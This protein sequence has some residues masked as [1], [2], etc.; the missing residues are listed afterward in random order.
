MSHRPNRSYSGCSRS[1]GGIPT[2][3]ASCTGGTWIVTLTAALL[4]ITAASPCPDFAGRPGQLAPPSGRRRSV[5]PNALA[6]AIAKS[7]GEVAAMTR[8]KLL[9]ILLRIFGIGGLFALGAVFMPMSW[10]VAIHSWL[11]LGDMPTAPIVEY[12]ARTVSVFYVVV[13][14]V[15]LA[16]TSDLDRY[17][18]LVRLLGV[19]LALTGIVFTGTDLAAGM[20]W[21]WTAAEGPPVVAFGAVIFFLAGP[22]AQGR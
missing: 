3:A 18:P 6:A 2:A 8:P 10:M 15:F 17:R 1:A 19:T 16:V 9:V 4:T 22:T 14:V 11:G 5:F 13:S 7:E 12:L 20:P 21:W